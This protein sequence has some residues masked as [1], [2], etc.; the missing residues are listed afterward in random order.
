MPVPDHFKITKSL[1][2]SAAETHA[3]ERAHFI[4]IQIILRPSGNLKC[5]ER[6]LRAFKCS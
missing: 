6:T 4:F 1:S 3:T 5:T 2:V